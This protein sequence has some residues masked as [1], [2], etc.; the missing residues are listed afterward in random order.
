M[1]K[2]EPVDDSAEAAPVTGELVTPPAAAVIPSPAQQNATADRSRGRTAIQVGIPTAIVGIGVWILR[3]A[4]LDL[5][6]LPG[7]EDLPPDVAGYFVA[8]VTMIICYRMNPKD[9]TD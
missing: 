3:L 6:P 9:T 5:N 7:Q 2:P 4:H 1:P 8:V